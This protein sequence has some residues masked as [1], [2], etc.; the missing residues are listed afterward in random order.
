MAPSTKESA[1]YTGPED[2]GA[3]SLRPPATRH[4][5]PPVAIVPAPPLR[6]KTMERRW[7]IALAIMCGVAGIGVG[8]GIGA[9][10]FAR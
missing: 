4:S 2:L 5:L 3:G 1:I 6:P 10:L 8:I 7:A 9:L